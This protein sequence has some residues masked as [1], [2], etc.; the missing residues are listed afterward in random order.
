MGEIARKHAKTP[1]QI[2][3][4]WH[5]DSGLIVTQ[6]RLLRAGSRR[7]SMSSASNSMS[8]ISPP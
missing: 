4:R 1:A 2:I 3:I 5:I 7:I 8:R 6:N